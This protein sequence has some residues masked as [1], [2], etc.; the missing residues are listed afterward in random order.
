MIGKLIGSAGFLSSGGTISGDLT[1]TGDLTVNPGSSTYSYDEA[2]YGNVMYLD[3]EV[4]HGMTGLGLTNAYGSIEQLNTN[5][6]GIQIRGMSD[7]AAGIGV[8]IYGTIGVT[9]PTDAVPAVEI[10][11]SKKSGTS[12]QALAAA[13]TVF[14]VGNLG[15]DLVTVLGSGNVGIGDIAPSQLLEVGSGGSLLA[16]TYIVGD[17]STSNKIYLP[18][19]NNVQVN[20]Y[21]N[22]L[23]STSSGQSGTIQIKP[24]D[25]ARM[26]IDDNSRI[27]LSNNDENTY[28]TVFGYHALTNDGTV[29]GDV[30]A[31]YNVAVGHDSMG[32]GNTTDATFNTAVGY[33][34][35]RNI[36]SG[37]N[38]ASLGS[39][40]GDV[41]T[42]GTQNT[43]IGSGSDPSA[44]SG[45]NQSVIGYGTTGVADNSVTLGNANVTAVYAA[46]DKGAK[47]YCGQLELGTTGTGNVGVVI[48]SSMVYYSYLAGTSSQV[49]F[50]F[51]NA[52]GDVGSIDSSGSNTSYGT[53][54]DYRLKENQVTLSDGINR[55]NK[56]KPYRF[57]FK[58]DK[59]TTQDGFFA[60][61]VAEV[62]PE[63][64]TGEK[65]AVDGDGNMITQHIDH[66]KL[67]PLLVK[68][69][70]E[71]T[72]KVEALEAK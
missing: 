21:G 61:E 34:S 17:G 64:I 70:Q 7:A 10:R 60:H 49:H 35:L 67:V 4:A 16:R 58:A 29:L 71:L 43:I 48:N 55:L 23:L 25:T 8:Q 1:I 47:V 69:V 14:Q 24:L 15:T 22:L 37:D 30:G 63:A 11:G 3:S 20:A 36:I 31:D 33:L 41:I 2:I 50:V 56:L 18:S 65:D 28:N 39:S 68:A 57:N 66:S 9:D 46:S 26:I 52:N 19:G 5:N 40:A 32:A 45:T 54:S 59:D 53:T 72:A 51:N 12:H 44:N 42:T 62:V 27:S 38:N 13:E 6:G